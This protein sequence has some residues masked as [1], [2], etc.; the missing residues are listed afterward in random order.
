M[1]SR[2][3]LFAQ[4]EELL[5]A[6]GNGDA[7][8][9]TL[10]IMQ[11]TLGDRNPLFK[12]LEAVSPEHE[13]TVRELAA[14]RAEGYPLQYLLGEWEFY[15]C[16]MKVGE[17]VLIP[18]PDTETLVDAAIEL[19]RE[20]RLTSPRIADLCSGSGCI[21]VAL[22]KEIPGSEVT[23]IELSE[24]AFGYLTQNIK[25]NRSA[26][27]AVQA[28]VLDGNTARSFTELDMIVSNPPY[29]TA[30]EMAELQQE[31]RFEPE[32]ALAAGGDGLSFYR[33]IPAI[34]RESLKPGGIIAFE[35]GDRQHED[36]AGILSECGFGNISFRH[37]AAGIA[38]V[39]TAEKQEEM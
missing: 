36:V 11:D 34:W 8:F 13:K 39:V 21:A 32:S 16:P 19:C 25:L 20:R 3:E 33:A 38:R 26:V 15:G 31:V 23:A 12:P 5:S 17:G 14:R 35:V 10:C 1:V 9:D 37:D 2:A 4:C 24:A 27:K 22:G 18:R 28:D 7:R 29:L 30:Q 6:A